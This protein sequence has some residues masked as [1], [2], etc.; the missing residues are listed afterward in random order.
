MRVLV[1]R[2]KA[3]ISRPPA[4]FPCVPWA[5]LLP[6]GE[7]SGVAQE[8]DIKTCSKY[9]RERFS[10]MGFDTKWNEVH[11]IDAGWSFPLP[12]KN[13]PF[14][15]L[16]EGYWKVFPSDCLLSYLN[17]C[18]SI[19]KQRLCWMYQSIRVRKAFFDVQY[20]EH[21]LEEWDVYYSITLVKTESTIPLSA[22]KQTEQK[23]STFTFKQ[24]WC[25]RCKRMSW[26]LGNGRFRP[27]LKAAQDDERW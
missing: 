1:E 3:S 2:I 16:L 12:L 17:G 7:D 19:K 13:F 10:R 4:T 5:V 15:V 9:P 8:T 21:R 23:K 18:W 26:V 20:Q 24:F 25:L 14:A 22:E 6:T 27:R 11:L